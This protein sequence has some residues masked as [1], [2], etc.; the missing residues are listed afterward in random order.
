MR[1]IDT[2]EY[3]SVLRELTEAGQEVCMRISGNS[4]SPFLI[5]GR[6]SICFRKP[7]R[8]LKA[9]DMVFFQRMSGQYVM[10][11]ICKVRPEGY[12]II[13]DAQQEIE[14]PVKQEQI[15]ALIEKVNRKGK[16]IGPGDFWWEFFAHI[17][18]RV[19][20]LRQILMKLYG[21]FR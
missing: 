10:H 19:I 18:L 9:G 3:V 11:R 20:P 2:T 14:G 16:W 4:M 7:D 6:D 21:R 5:H 8:P 12:Y 15:F 1:L 17:W 13:G